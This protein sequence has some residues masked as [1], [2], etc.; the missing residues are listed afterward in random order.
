MRYNDRRFSIEGGAGLMGKYQLKSRKEGS[1]ITLLEVD[2]ECRAWYVKADDK[3][4][5]VKTLISMGES[6][7]RLESIYVNGDD[8]TEDIL[9][10]FSAARKTSYPEE[11]MPESETD[12]FAPQGS[13]MPP[14]EMMPDD[15]PPPDEYGYEE[16]GAAPLSPLPSAEEIEAAASQSGREE[17]SIADERPS[18]FA[19]PDILPDLAS[20]LPKT[21]FVSSPKKNASG[22]VNGMYLGKK[23][24]TGNPVEIRTIT[25]EADG[26]VFVG[27]VINCEMRE[28]R[29]KKK[30][31]LMSLADETNGISCKK[32]FDRPEEAGGLE[33]LKAGMA[34]KVRGNVRFDKYSG[35]LVLELQQVEKGEIIKIDH[36]DDY[37]T[38]RVELHLHTKMSLDGLIDNEEI[39]KTAA[40]WHHPAVA[41]TDHGVIQAFPK[42]QD[43]ADKYKQKVIYGMEGYMIEDIPADP[44]TDR[45]QYNHIIILA[46][47]VTGLRNLYRMVT[48]SHLKF[49]RKRPLIP[50]PILKELHEGLIYGSACVMGEFFRAVLAGK[51]DEELIEMAKFYDYLEVQPLGN[52]EFL[53]NDDKFAEVN[54]EKD[55]QDLNRK[56]IEI[57][58][59]AG[60]PVCATSDA[61]YMFAEDQRNRDILLSN[62]EKP[63]KIESH[64]PVYMR[65]TQEML[66]EFSYLPKEKALEIVVEN[67]RRIAEEC[68]VLHPLAEEWKSYNPKISGADEKLVEMCYSN[69]KAIYGD[70]LPKEVQER[71][72]LELTPIIKHGYG[73]LYYI[74]HKLV[75]HSNDR[76]YLV[77]SRGSVGSSFVATMSGITEVNPLPPHYVCPNCHWTHFYT[78]GSV[79][80]GFDLPDK[81]CPECGHPLNKNGHNIPFAVFLGFDGDKVPDIDL[82]FSSG[83][84]QGVAHKYTEELFGRDNVFRAGTIAGI[85]DKTAYGFV[86]KYA[87]NRGLTFNDIFIEKLSAGVAGVKRTTGQHPAGIMVC[88]RDMDIHNFTPLQYAAN[89]KYQK[90]TAS[91]EPLP[92]ISIT[93]PSRAVC[94]SW[95]SWAT[96]ILRLS[97]CSRILRASIRLRFHLMTRRHCLSSAPLKHWALR[98]SSLE[99]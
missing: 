30:L 74:A 11:F 9:S 48:L 68:E 79:G 20:V 67:T 37:P 2:T 32:F 29:S 59:K 93:I 69:A 53:I 55:L 58:E 13:Y 33:E 96:M 70:P 63:G 78:D 25:D 72:T 90:E 80:G 47:N 38:P 44:D 71:L 23:H 82:N 16:A 40:K 73:V 4:A 5:A 26:V 7:R 51:S 27:T 19:M 98:R 10:A 85:Q 77:G 34:V 46:K 89:K 84:D 45:Q 3:D 64:P 12:D 39:I 14:E 31:F 91:P 22:A 8:M 94:S 92:P 21:A 66:D 49:Y 60:R 81:A 65:T 43:L 1:V 35:G 83:D 99:P 54:S 42:I 86:K 17:A 52:N 88:P 50:K 28:L 41:I 62:W 87:E 36:E 61:H 56:V 24:I 76:G 97:A 75:K 15:V 6:I 57:G 18:E 95:I